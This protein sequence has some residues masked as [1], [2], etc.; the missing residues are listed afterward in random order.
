MMPLIIGH[1]GAAAT[2]PENT[3]QGMREALKQG[4]DGVE[5][6]LRVSRDGRLHLLHDSSLERT[7]GVPARLAELDA[8]QVAELDATRGW[9]ACSAEAPPRLEALLAWLPA[10]R[11][12]L[13]EWKEAPPQDARIAV[14]LRAKRPGATTAMISF[15][16][17]ILEGLKECC[18]EYRRMLLLDKAQ[19]KPGDCSWLEHC[20][21]L[22][23]D[24][25]DA[26]ATALLPEHLEACRNAGLA[27][28]AWDV[29]TRGE[30]RRLQ[31]L[32]VDLM[33]TDRPARLR[34]WLDERHVT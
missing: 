18:P 32:G 9:P 30:A 7:C 4:A 29:E 1:R 3:L 13:L 2:A 19:L 12:L 26:R 33:T 22:G 23:L 10:E 20:H 25:I 17:G 6:D 15:D 31:E 27:C 24:G 5:T 28:W 16:L 21:R 14:Q 34:G 11:W 8:V